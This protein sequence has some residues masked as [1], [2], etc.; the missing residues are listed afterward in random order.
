MGGGR[1]YWPDCTDAPRAAGSRPMPL[2]G[3]SEVVSRAVRLHPAAADQGEPPHR[4]RV[5]VLAAIGP[6]AGLDVWVDAPS[7]WA[8]VYAQLVGE[9]EGV[10]TVLAHRRI[11][12]VVSSR[13]AMTNR[14]AGILFSSRGRAIGQTLVECFRPTEAVGGEATFTASTVPAAGLPL[15]QA[16]LATTDLYARADQQRLYTTAGGGLPGSPAVVMA[17]NPRG[18]GIG[19]TAL[20]VSTTSATRGLCVLQYQNG[21]APPVALWS[22]AVTVGNPIEMTWPQ[23]LYTPADAPLAELQATITMIDPADVELSIA[24]FYR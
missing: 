13:P 23:P 22:G 3:P 20:H 9:V 24:T 7:S 12:S 4:Q 2:V 19:V 6:Y 10:R 8:D 17:P 15:D 5:G 1:G 16:D 11:G 18:A 14:I 21:V